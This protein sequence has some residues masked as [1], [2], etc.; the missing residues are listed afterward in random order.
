MF[1]DQR[2]RIDTLDKEIMRLLGERFQVVREVGRIKTEKDITIVQTARCKEVLDHVAALGE[3]HDFA[4]DVARHIYTIL[5]DYAH[6]L[7]NEIKDKQS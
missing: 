7:E 1:D 6:D 3:A 5:I 2:Q 4:P